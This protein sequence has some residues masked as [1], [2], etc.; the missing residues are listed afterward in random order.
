MT[1]AEAENAI[2][3]GSATGVCVGRMSLKRG[4]WVRVD[5]SAACRPLVLCRPFRSATPRLSVLAICRLNL[6]PPDSDGQ[7]HSAPR[8]RN[9]A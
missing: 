3:A 8:A 6:S 9:P 1:D 7:G 5:L 2:D 4:M